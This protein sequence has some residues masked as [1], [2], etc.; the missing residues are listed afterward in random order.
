MLNVWPRQTALKEDFVVLRCLVLATTATKTKVQTLQPFD[1]I[2]T[3]VKDK[4]ER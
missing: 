1:K 2:C 4:N 3:V